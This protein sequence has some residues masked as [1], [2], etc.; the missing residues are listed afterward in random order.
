MPNRA[1]TLAAAKSWLNVSAIDPL[2]SPLI[3]SSQP[4][5]AKL[6]DANSADDIDTCT[7]MSM[8][9]RSVVEVMVPD[10][11]AEV[12]GAVPVHAAPTRTVADVKLKTAMMG[13]LLLGGWGCY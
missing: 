9:D 5:D 1:S 13:L 7:W 4:P 8:D 3:F 12:P 6:V 2:A 10:G 11:V